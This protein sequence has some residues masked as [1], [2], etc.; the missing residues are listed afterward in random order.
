MRKKQI[1]NIKNN[2]SNNGH[3][4]RSRTSPSRENPENEITNEN[5]SL[6]SLCPLCFVLYPTPDIEVNNNF[7]HLQLLIGDEVAERSKASVEALPSPV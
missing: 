7:Y 3:Q 1:K 5:I 6:Q 4:S 2:I